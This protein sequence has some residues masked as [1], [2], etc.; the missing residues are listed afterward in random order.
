MN[1]RRRFDKH[2]LWFSWISVVVYTLM[3]AMGIV[4]IAS[5]ALWPLYVVA[6]L[7]IW[8]LISGVWEAWHHFKL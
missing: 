7:C 2:Q 4:G 8:L 6:A 3:I 1:T 5:G